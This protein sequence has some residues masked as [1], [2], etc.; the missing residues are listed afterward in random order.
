M[1]EEAASTFLQQIARAHEGD[2]GARSKLLE[3]NI[4]LV[5]S[6]V[7]RFPSSGQE[8]EDLFQVGCMGLLRAID[9]FDPSYG[10]QFSTYA[11][12]LIIGEIRRYLR[13]QGSVKISRAVK[14]RAYRLR[15]MRDEEGRKLGREPTAEELAEASGLPMDQVVE[16]LEVLQPIAS[17]EEKLPGSRDQ[18]TLADRIVGSD[19][20]ELEAVRRVELMEEIKR[21]PDLERQVLYLRF[22]EDKTQSQ[23]AEVLGTNQVHISR[24][25]HKAL[26]H[27]RDHLRP[28]GAS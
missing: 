11:V 3:S 27:L 12:P 18:Q 22:F 10:V 2:Q 25:E 23:V 13:D 20:V 14:E 16:A 24:L 9:R 7:G 17:L 21:L 28:E 5:W 4:K 1:D 8:T 26:M 15:R 6:I 19:S